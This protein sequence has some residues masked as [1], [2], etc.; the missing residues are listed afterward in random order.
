ME[1]PDTKSNAARTQCG[2][3]GGATWQE[4]CCSYPGGLEMV[5]EGESE[6]RV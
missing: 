5:K 6:A 2:K 4:S 1:V 3:C